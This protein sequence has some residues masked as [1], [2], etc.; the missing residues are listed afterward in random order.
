MLTTEQRTTIL[1]LHRR[2]VGA[3]PIAKALGISR[4]TVKKVIREGSSEVPPIHREEKAGNWRDEILQLHPFCKGNLQRV[5][6][7]LV[8]Q[9]ADL[10]YQALTAFC[11]RHGIAQKPKKASGE[12][13]F[14]PGEEVQ[15]DTSPHRAPVAGTLRQ[16]QSAVTVA[17]FSRMIFFQGYPCFDRFHCK[18]F[19]TDALSY[20]EGVFK[21]MMIDN[22]HV[23]VLRGTGAE[24]VPVP[25]MAAFADRFGFV[26]E[27]HEKGDANRSARVE[28][29]MP[30]VENNFYAGRTFSSWEDLNRQAREWCDKVNARFRPSLRAKPV[31]L[32]ATEKPHLKPLPV[33]VPEVYRLHHRTV[34]AGAYVRVNTNRYSVPVDWVGRPVEIRET[35]DRIVVTLDTRNQ[36][37]HARVV[38]KT[39][40]TVTDP[41]HRPPRGRRGKKPDRTREEE[42]LASSYPALTEY[43][44][45]LKQKGRKQT[46]LALK[47]LLR[48]AREYP[49]DALMSAVGE[50]ARYGLYDLDRVERMVLRRVAEEYF[51][52]QPEREDDD[53]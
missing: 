16:V 5:H 38:E 50:A 37:S 4:T 3:R 48:M 14:D 43:V 15:H 10:S 47:Q 18:L 1:E 52:L 12:Y 34:D 29:V 24:M 22:T 36:V 19:L 33:W 28:G 20:Y 13:H 35:K 41:A 2:G 11:R 53:E 39:S 31:E 49:S 32:W 42:L 6:E 21:R 7:E 25:E 17:C 23:V 26:F 46:S 8:E 51:R 30:F 40:R 27:A 9:G 45:A 44:A